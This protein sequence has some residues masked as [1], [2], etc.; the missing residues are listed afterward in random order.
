MKK[1]TM[2]PVRFRSK[3]PERLYLNNFVKARVNGRLDTC[4][5]ALLKPGITGNRKNAFRISAYLANLRRKIF[6]TAAPPAY[7]PPEPVHWLQ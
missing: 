6:M 2:N 4:L 5:A 3:P 1:L 7:R